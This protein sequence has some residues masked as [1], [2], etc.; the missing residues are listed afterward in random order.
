M[1]RNMLTRDIWKIYSKKK[2]NGIR[3]HKTA[4]DFI[5]SSPL[6][7]I[8]PLSG[9]DVEGVKCSHF[10]LEGDLTSKV[11]NKH[12]PQRACKDRS[13][14]LYHEALSGCLDRE[15]NAVN[16]HM[17]LT[18]WTELGHLTPKPHTELSKLYC[19]PKNNLSFP[20]QSARLYSKTQ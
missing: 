11:N 9:Y 1:F 14:K 20:L 10:Q 4:R 15:E 3:N 17:P 18:V 5:I 8:L 13:S 19:S 6:L 12:S 2:Q 16:W 7:G